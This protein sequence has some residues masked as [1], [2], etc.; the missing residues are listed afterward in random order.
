MRLPRRNS[1]E[2]FTVTEL[3]VFV[4][5]LAVLAAIFLP[6]LARQRAS[7]CR[8]NCVNNLKQIGLAFRSWAL[9]NNDNYPM[10]VSVT[11]GGTME[12]VARGFV[13]PHF[14]VMSNEL[15][16]PMILICPEEAPLA[17]KAANTFPLTAPAAN[18]GIGL[19]PLASD[20]NVSYFVGLDARIDRPDMLLCGDRNLAFGGVPARHGIQSVSTNSTAVWIKPRPRH[21]NGG[22][23]CLADDSVLS[24]RGRLLQT[25]HQQTG[26]ATNRLAF[27]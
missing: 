13:F 4:G 9:D 20:Y 23:I 1:G 25:L 11:N 14:Q 12:L 26:A 10:Q 27:P 6:A 2:A 7:H 16:T 19:V 21:N 15:S 3:L 8:I 17:R 22:N 24:A 5:T 18:T